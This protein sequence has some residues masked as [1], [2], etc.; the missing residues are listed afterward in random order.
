MHFRHDWREVSRQFNP[1]ARHQV[2][3]DGDAYV[4]ADITEKAIH[5]FTKVEYVCAREG[6][7][8]RKV[9]EF[10]GKLPERTD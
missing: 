4:V 8:K 1:P 7:A 10:V 3:A 9:L 2:H 6:C 5:G